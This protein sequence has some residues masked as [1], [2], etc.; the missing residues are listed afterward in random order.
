LAAAKQQEKKTR[1]M[2]LANLNSTSLDRYLG[3]CIEHSLLV[4]QN[5]G[6]QVTSRAE[7]TLEA[8]NAVL[9]K[10]SQLNE[11]V[12]EFARLAGEMRWSRGGPNLPLPSR[13]LELDAAHPSWLSGS[14]AIAS[15]SDEIGL[16]RRK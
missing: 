16:R 9:S 11:A 5:G 1:I 3:Y 12:E 4:P 8:I 15:L 2:G 6:F 7:Q 13:P 14:S 10:G